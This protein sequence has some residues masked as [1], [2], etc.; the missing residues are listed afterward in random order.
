MLLCGTTVVHHSLCTHTLTH[1]HT[2]TPTHPHTHTL[3]SLLSA[4]LSALCSV[5]HYTLCSVVQASLNSWENTEEFDEG[6]G[7]GGADAW[8]AD[9]RQGLDTE[10]HCNA[11]RLEAAYALARWQTNH[12]PLSAAAEGSGSWQVQCYSC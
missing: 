12:A 11:V 1:S 5:V 4:L 6:A 7:A 10:S 2:H 8:T 3:Y 9:G